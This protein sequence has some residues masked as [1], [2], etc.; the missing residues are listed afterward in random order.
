MC[1]VKYKILSKNKANPDISPNSPKH[2]S[3]IKN[4]YAFFIG[5]AARTLP[6]V[7]KFKRQN[8]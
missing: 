8:P 6:N 7:L 2:I 1:T 5:H 3:T 4:F